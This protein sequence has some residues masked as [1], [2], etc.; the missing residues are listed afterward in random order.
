MALRIGSA[1][2][3]AF[4]PAQGGQFLHGFR[5]PHAPDVGQQGLQA[6]FFPVPAIHD[7]GSQ[8]AQGPGFGAPVG[9]DQAPDG[10]PHPLGNDGRVAD[11]RVRR[12]GGLP[13]QIVIHIQ[14]VIVFERGPFT[15]QVARQ[16]RI[17]PWLAFRT[18][19]RESSRRKTGEQAQRQQDT[20]R[21]FMAVSPQC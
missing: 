16:L 6:F 7:Q 3:K 19:L 13:V 2:E 20:K 21:F 4:F 18:V 17:D 5:F 8:D 12:L 10:I 15:G 11:F 1:K 9:I 14:V